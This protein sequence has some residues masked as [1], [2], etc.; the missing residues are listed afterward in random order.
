VCEDVREAGVDVASLRVSRLVGLSHA[1]DVAE[2]GVRAVGCCAECGR[3]LY[4]SG[5]REMSEDISGD[6]SAEG[7]GW[8]ESVGWW[9]TWTVR[10]FRL[11]VL[12]LVGLSTEP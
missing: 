10:R 5:R 6:S 3:W 8:A 7:G 9:A 11:L 12:A 1:N 2:C 4:G